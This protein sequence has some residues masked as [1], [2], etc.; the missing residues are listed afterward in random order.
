M[1]TLLKSSLVSYLLS[2]IG[3]GKPNDQAQSPC[4]REVTKE[5]DIKIHKMWIITATFYY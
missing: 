5:I 1:Q 3:Q 4:E 2:P